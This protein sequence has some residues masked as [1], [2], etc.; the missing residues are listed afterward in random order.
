MAIIKKLI[1]IF[2]AIFTFSC[3]KPTTDSEICID[4]MLERLDMESYEGNIDAICNNYLLYFTEK[5]M[6][7]FM[8]ENPCA[9]L[10]LHLWDCDKIDICENDSFECQ[11]IMMNMTHQGVIGRSR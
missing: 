10:V 4:N 1:L 2:L 9:D 8:L 5:G 11:T 3:S 7:Y 6:D